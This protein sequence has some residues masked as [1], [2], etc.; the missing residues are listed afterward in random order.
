MNNGRVAV[1]NEKI[2]ATI[3]KRTS[4]LLGTIG[5]TALSQRKRSKRATSNAKLMQMF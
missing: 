1:F 5:Y 4:L 2:S 3:R